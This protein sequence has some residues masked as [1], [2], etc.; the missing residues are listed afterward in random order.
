MITSCSGPSSLW[1][2]E[3]VVKFVACFETIYKQACER[4][5]TL[6]KLQIWHALLKGRDMYTIAAGQQDRQQLRMKEVKKLTAA[7]HKELKE[8]TAL[9]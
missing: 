1:T 7:Q 8:L 5:Q 2:A 3:T 6:N 9:D 4:K